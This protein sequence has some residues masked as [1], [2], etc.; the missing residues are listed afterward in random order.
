MKKRVRAAIKRIVCLMTICSLIAGTCP[1]SVVAAKE[2]SKADSEK[3]NDGKSQNSKDEEKNRILC[4][5][6][7][8]TLENPM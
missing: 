8:N 3:D 7:L 4:H 6:I 1:L 2:E 5:R